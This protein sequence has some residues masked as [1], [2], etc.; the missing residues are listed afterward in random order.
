MFCLNDT[1]YKV[2]FVEIS[3]NFGVTSEY[4]V[5]L[6][7]PR[8]KHLGLEHCRGHPVSLTVSAWQG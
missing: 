7:L 4:K 5:C 6:V 3:M 2:K 8:A 1:I